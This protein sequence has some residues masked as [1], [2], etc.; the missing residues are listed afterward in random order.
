MSRPSVPRSS[1]LPR[2]PATSGSS[3]AAPNTF[4]T[5]GVEN[6]VRQAKEAAGGRHLLVSGGAS[7]VDQCLA[8]GLVDE[9]DL[10][11]APILLGAGKRLFAGVGRRVELE[12]LGA[13]QSRYATHL[14]YRVVR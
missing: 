2:S 6:A 13:L 3:A 4:V 11:V 12:P 9:I 14:R 5:D 7:V 8:A 10:H 1:C